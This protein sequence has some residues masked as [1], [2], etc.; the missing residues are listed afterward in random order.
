M[1]LALCSFVK[2]PLE[3]NAESIG[4]VIN[5]HGSKERASLLPASLS[6]EVQVNWNGPLEFSPSATKIIKEA[7]DLYFQGKTTGLCFYTNS[8]A[9]IISTTVA[10]FMKR[11]SRIDF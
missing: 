3:A 7:L 9:K 1:H 4:S 8:K 2:A 5:R 11:P 10:S 6:N